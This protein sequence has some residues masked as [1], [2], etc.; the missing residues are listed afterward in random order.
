VRRILARIVNSNFIES[1]GP[2]ID[3]SYYEI[4]Y[5]NIEA[6]REGDTSTPHEAFMLV[7]ESQF[8]RRVKKGDVLELLYDDSGVHAQLK[9]MK[10][11]EKFSRAEKEQLEMS[12]EGGYAKEP[13]P[14]GLLDKT[15]K[16]FQEIKETV[17]T[18]RAE[19]I[20]QQYAFDFVK[21]A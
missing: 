15:A 7:P 8:P 21:A 3:V 11:K 4:T 12:L 18:G 10:L 5:S 14:G 13:E 17:S 19:A 16:K 6:I 2:I 1:V 20:Q 9:H